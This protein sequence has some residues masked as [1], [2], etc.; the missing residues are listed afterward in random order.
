MSYEKNI[1]E[2]GS[3]VPDYA[4]VPAREL[5][6]S[7]AV[8]ITKGVVYSPLQ[9]TDVIDEQEL[10][11]VIEED[12][13]VPDVKPDLSRIL[14]LTGKPSL[15]TRETDRIARDDDYVNVSGELELQTIYVPEKDGDVLPL[16]SIQTKLPFKEQWRASLAE[17]AALTLDCRVEDLA[18]MVVNERKFRIKASLRISARQYKDA[19]ADVFEGLIDEDL[20]TLKET[21]EISSVALRKKD[22]LSIKEDLAFKDDCAPRSILRQDVCAVENYQQVAGDKIVVNGFIYINLL[23]LGETSEAETSCAQCLRQ[24]QD[25]VEFTQFI[26]LPQAGNFSGVDLCFD[27]SRL[28]VKIAQD[29]D[30]RDVLRLDGELLTYA[31]LYKNS[32]QELIVDA[33]HREK[34][35]VCEFEEISCKALVAVTSGETSVREIIALDEDE[36]DAGSVIFTSARVASCESH[37]EQ[38]KI[39][40]E[41]SLAVS[42]IC[43]AAGDEQQIFAKQS[44]LPFRVATAAPQLRGGEIISQKVYVKDF[45]A[46]K[47]NGR[48]LEFNAS[49][50]VCALVLR[51]APFKVLKNPAFEEGSQPASVPSMAICVC[52]SGDS[53]W[54]IAKRY[55]TTVE[56]ITAVNELTSDSLSEGQKLLVV[57]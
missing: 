4:L 42:M 12:V 39:V 26:P 11:L 49:I 54:Q 40:T 43:L 9:V 27:D 30:G 37:A 16:V 57:R 48:Q 1:S 21:V 15:T 47:I 24:F 6:E 22:S 50:L 17:G 19:K 52:R 41:G 8:P 3:G 53:L 35:F 14:L 56:K 33:Y 18:Y 38:G 55:K 5:S 51:P 36:A 34:D 10:N 2:Y 7:T 31:A 32:Q 25:K 23:Y 45:W 20:P 29:E 46:E 13:L 28:R 44:V